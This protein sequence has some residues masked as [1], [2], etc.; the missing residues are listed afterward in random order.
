M[1][2]HYVNELNAS[3][4][5][6]SLYIKLPQ[7]WQRKWS[8]NVSTLLSKAQ[9]RALFAEFVDFTRKESEVANDPTFSRE[10]LSKVIDKHP[11]KV[12]HSKPAKGAS[13]L[14]ITSF[15]IKSGSCNTSNEAVVKHS[16][17]YCSKEHY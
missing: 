1:D 9:R 4:L 15:V 14:K 2:Q 17:L 8:E 5:V 10:A 13:K 6:Q 11:I 12:D 7:R 3:T 16:R